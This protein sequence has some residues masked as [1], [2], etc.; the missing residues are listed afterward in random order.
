MSSQ[1]LRGGSVRII[2][3]WTQWGHTE[4]EA[5][6][7]AVAHYEFAAAARARAILRDVLSTLI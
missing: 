5:A 2:C 3:V 6:S 4:P 1:S 7:A